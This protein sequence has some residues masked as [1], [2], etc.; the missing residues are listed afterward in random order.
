MLTPR[1]VPFAVERPALE[2]DLRRDQTGVKM[3]TVAKCL[4]AETSS[5]GR[6]LTSTD[7]Q[8][9]STRVIKEPF[10]NECWTHALTSIA[11]Q[12]I[13]SAAMWIPGLPGAFAQ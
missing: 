2:N 12:T 4:P 11:N 1:V 6:T 13:I 8:W 5:G 10:T 3:L 9:S 7:N